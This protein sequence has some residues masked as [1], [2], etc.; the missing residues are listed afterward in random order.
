VFQQQEAEMV[1]E[2]HDMKLDMERDSDSPVSQL[3]VSSASDVDDA[4]KTLRDAMSSDSEGANVLF[5]GKDKWQSQDEASSDDEDFI[6]VMNGSFKTDKQSLPPGFK[7]QK[8]RQLSPEL[9]GVGVAMGE[10][11]DL[12]EDNADVGEDE[13]LWLERIANQADDRYWDNHVDV[14]VRK[15]QKGKPKKPV[16]ESHSTFSIQEVN[17]HFLTWHTLSV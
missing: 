16:Q 15:Q 9:S 13:R 7:K 14:G 12:S 1:G 2:M 10:T 3:D 5:N 4:Y 6:A 8:N 17:Q 11:S